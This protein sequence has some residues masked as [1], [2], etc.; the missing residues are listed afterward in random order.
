MSLEYGPAS[1]PLH[2][3]VKW[4]AAALL[5]T[6]GYWAD[7]LMQEIVELYDS[8]S[9]EVNIHVGPYSRK[10]LGTYAGR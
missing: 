8:E 3:S 10:F 9:S 1:E 2:I 4:F 6:Q 5:S 7:W